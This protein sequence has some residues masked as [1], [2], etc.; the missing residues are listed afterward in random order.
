[1][2]LH[3]LD[4]WKYSVLSYYRQDQSF[5]QAPLFSS[6]LTESQEVERVREELNQSEN[7]KIRLQTQ[8]D[9]EAQQKTNMA[10]ENSQLKVKLEE[11]TKQN[12][13]YQ[14]Q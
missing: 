4:T 9:I 2:V 10:D 13:E 8:I 1:M 5:S 6:S 14:V 7:D 12:N 3:T 11:V